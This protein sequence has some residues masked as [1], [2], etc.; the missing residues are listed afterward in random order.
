M[1]EEI[2]SKPESKIGN[3]FVRIFKLAIDEVASSTQKLG[4][5]S[6]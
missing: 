4:R 3:P 1:K 6:L 2:K 5:P